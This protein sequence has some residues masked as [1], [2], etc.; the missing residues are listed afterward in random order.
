MILPM[1]AALFVC[2]GLIQL[3]ALSVWV[4]VLSFALKL[5]I[6]VTILLAL[7]L[8]LPYLW[9]KYRGNNK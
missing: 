8:G 5:I 1:I 3:G 2:M 4:S 6:L 7:P 9:R